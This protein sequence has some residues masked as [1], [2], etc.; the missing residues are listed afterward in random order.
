MNDIEILRLKSRGY[1]CSRILVHLFLDM[2]G[3]VNPGLSAFANGLCMGA[4]SGQG[5]CGI[6]TAGMGI[7]ALYAGEETDRLALMQEAFHTLFL[8]LAPTGPAC[9]AISGD[10]WPHPNPKTCGPLLSRAHDGLL[11]LLLENGFDPAEMADD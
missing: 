10:L 2:A 8:T 4:G 3:K 6:L 7:L 5:P 1:C 11:A 9:N